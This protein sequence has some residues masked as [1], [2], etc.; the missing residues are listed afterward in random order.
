MTEH[1]APSGAGETRESAR[2]PLRLKGRRLLAGTA[3]SLLGLRTQDGQKLATS[4][5]AA[6]ARRDWSAAAEAYD[7]ALTS[8]PSLNATWVQ[9]GHALKEH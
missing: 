7:R 4:G 1:L 5:D 9:F 3:R 8:D 6:M 2:G